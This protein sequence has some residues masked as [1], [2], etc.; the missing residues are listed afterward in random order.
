MSDR[1]TYHKHAA[2][3]SLVLVAHVMGLRTDLESVNED[4]PTDSS[5]T[6]TGTELIRI[7]GAAG[8]IAK[9]KKV[10]AEFVRTLPLPA[11]VLVDGGR[12]IALAQMDGN[13]ALTQDPASTDN[14]APKIESIDSFCARFQ[15]E[16]LLLKPKVTE[17]GFMRFGLSWFIPYI[18]KYK[19]LL[20]EVLTI[21]VAL[22]LVS[23]ASPLFFQV[24]TDKVL[25]HRSLSTLDVIVVGLLVVFV[26]EALLNFIRSYIL[27]HTTSKIDVELGSALF[28]HL[29]ALPMAY[30]ES[31]KVGDSV[32]RMRELESLR[33]FLTGHAITLLIDVVFSTV[34]IAV[35]LYYSSTMT[36]IVLCSF[37]FY[38]AVILPLVPMLR[39]RLEVKFERNAANQ[40]MLVETITGIQTVKGNALQHRFVR[41]WDESLAKYVASSFRTGVLAS[42]GQELISLI[43]KLT[44]V[45]TLWWGSHEVMDGNLTIGMF[46]AFNMLS[47]RLTQPILRIAQ[48]WSDFQQV[49][50]S[51]SRLADVL[52]VPSENVQS[53]SSRRAKLVGEIDF[54]NV[55]FRYRPENPPVIKD[56]TF[57]IRAGETVA[58]VGRS[59]SGKSTISK[60]IQKM[61]SIDHGAIL[62][63]GHDI[64]TFNTAVLRRQI[65]IVLQDNFIFA[66]SIRDNIAIAEPAASDDHI[67]AAARLAGAHEFINALPQGYDT[68]VGEHGVGLSGGQKQRIAIARALI[69]APPILILDEATSALDY[70]SEAAIQANMRDICRGRTVII[71]AHR[72]SAIRSA[73]RIVVMD[74]GQ[75]AE[76]GSHQELMAMNGTYATLCAMQ[77]DAATELTWHPSQDNP[78]IFAGGPAR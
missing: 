30:F 57:K 41:Q 52:D 34:F 71:I 7:A 16:I 31:R 27:S 20:L 74:D 4:C 21:S 47:Q 70:E 48:L 28:R 33:E 78:C 66:R 72:L 12:W 24:V 37:P 54:T 69:S 44:S 61:Y 10:A 40:S 62:I 39:E 36:L 22:Q 77:A 38:A 56:L 32:A 42:G 29:L 45:A 13:R 49:G 25:A 23:L 9:H 2:V 67:I 59:G 68:V 65:G 63:D 76:Q 3:S 1:P 19:R 75:I 18:A 26:F 17:Q 5:A 64:R 55:L 58:I 60:L 50:I 11:L 15:G 46:I 14:A 51:I 53:A 8:L 6:C 43:S 73:G 35:M